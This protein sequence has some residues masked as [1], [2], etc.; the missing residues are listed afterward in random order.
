MNA[1]DLIHLL[2]PGE[3]NA[4]VEAKTETKGKSGSSPANSLG[5]SVRSYYYSTV[6][7]PHACIAFAVGF[8]EEAGVVDINLDV[9]L[10]KFE[11]KQLY[12]PSDGCGH[13]PYPC[14]LGTSK[15]KPL[16]PGNSRR[17]TSDI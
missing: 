9:Y 6:P 13:E 1:P 17:V 8:W 16:H 10:D 11:P 12:L 5:S 15:S 2:D 7:L 4:K 3:A 14:R